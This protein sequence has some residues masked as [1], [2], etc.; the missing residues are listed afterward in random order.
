LTSG[1]KRLPWT[2]VIVLVTSASVQRAVGSGPG[3]VCSRAANGRSGRGVRKR[4]IAVR[5]VR[6]R[7]GVGGVG[8]R[9]SAIAAPI[10]GASGG[11]NNPS[12]IDSASAN[13]PRRQLRRRRCA[14]ASAQR[15]R[16]QI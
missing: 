10:R 3:A 8:N 16:V 6:K 12:A 1:S 5:A 7:H 15:Q 13:V 4:A 9:A 11:A 14:R 2:E